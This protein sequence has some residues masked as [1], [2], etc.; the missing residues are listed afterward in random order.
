MQMNLP[1]S[2]VS[3]GWENLFEIYIDEDNGDF[4]VNASVRK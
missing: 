2:I 4:N 3:T 1:V